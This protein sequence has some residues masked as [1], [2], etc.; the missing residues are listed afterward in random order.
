MPQQYDEV[1]AV[2]ARS[3]YELAD[4]AGNLDK[5]GDIYDEL[6]AVVEMTRADANLHEFFSSPIIGVGR[7]R[8]SLRTIFDGRI[9]DMI[10]RFLLVA[11][12]KGRL[13]HLEQIA[14]AYDALVQEAH[15]RVEVDLITASDE[16]VGR[17]LIESVKKRVHDVFGKEPVLHHHSDPAMIGGIKLRIG[18]QL[19]DGSVATRLRRMK[20]EILGEGAAGVRAETGRFLDD[21]KSKG[22]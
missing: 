19:L 2:Y 4:E 10:L 6:L 18:D 9:S 11:N 20:E 7:R 8:E 5:V 22:N 1:A 12:E 16:K 13:G 14:G 3:L 21:D 17:D 15:G